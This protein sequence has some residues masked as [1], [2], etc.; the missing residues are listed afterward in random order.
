METGAVI[1]NKTGTGFASDGLPLG[2]NDVGFVRL[3]NQRSYAIAVF[4]RSSQVDMEATENMIG[5]IS[6][7]VAAHFEVELR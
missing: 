1:G 3:P 7:I 5:G 4:I 2:I 6:A